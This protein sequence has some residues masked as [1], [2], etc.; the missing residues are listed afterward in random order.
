MNE[1]DV[2]QL[3]EKDAFLEV[4]HEQDPTHSTNKG[5]NKGWIPLSILREG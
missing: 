2:A 5:F 3:R 4:L 1:H